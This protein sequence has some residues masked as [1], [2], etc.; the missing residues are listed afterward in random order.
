MR[1]PPADRQD[2]LGNGVGISGFCGFL[3]IFSKKDTNLYGFSLFFKKN[4]KFDAAGRVS[5]DHFKFTT[6]VLSAENFFQIA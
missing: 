3:R 5:N 2:L 4:P 6:T 1:N